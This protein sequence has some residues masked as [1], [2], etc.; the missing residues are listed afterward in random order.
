LHVSGKYCF[1]D[2]ETPTI[3]CKL[4]GRSKVFKSIYTITYKK[5]NRVIAT[6]ATD[7]LEQIMNPGHGVLKIDNYYLYHFS[8]SIK[9]FIGWLLRRL[10]LEFHGITR[11][12]I[13][14][15]FNSFYNRREPENF[16][17][18]FLRNEILKKKK[19]KFKVAGN[20]DH[21]NTFNWI[22]FGS[23]TSTVNYK[24][25]NKSL[26]MKEAS[27]K[28]HILK[29]WK[30]SLLD[31]NKD[32]WRL[33]FTINSNTNT[34]MNEY[35]KINFHSLE[36]LSLDIISGIFYNLYESYFQ[37]VYNDRNQSR[38]DRMKEITLIQ[39]P[40]VFHKCHMIKTNPFER[41]SN[42]ATKIFINKM[43]SLQE[44]LRG[45]DDDFIEDARTMINKLI[46]IYKLEKWAERKGID[47]KNCNYASDL[48]DSQ[49]LN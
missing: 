13:A 28:P 1:Q 48:N 14:Y 21:I 43:N 15:D 18:A 22:T 25:Y 39:F 35:R 9:E 36:T 42:M 40:E 47:F 37:F 46:S 27:M 26:E 17:K 44:E 30:S 12:D 34:L 45:K 24:L 29:D 31:L 7:A 19:T 20:H 49:N 16:I 32:V 41:D 3:K 11:I 10:D 2:F 23:K 4:T 6:Y 8:S 5:H 38:K 33:E